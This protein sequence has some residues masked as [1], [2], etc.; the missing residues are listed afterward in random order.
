MFPATRMQPRFDNEPNVKGDHAFEM[1]LVHE[2]E[3]ASWWFLF[4][5]EEASARI[6]FFLALPH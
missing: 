4:R 2:G 5:L 3:N 6:N 1:A